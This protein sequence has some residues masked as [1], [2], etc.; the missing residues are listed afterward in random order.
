MILCPA[1]LSAVADGD[2]T[3]AVANR[4]MPDYDIVVATQDWHP[5]NHGSFAANHPCK[6]SFDVVDL[7]GLDQVL[8]PKKFA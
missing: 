4:L 8:W 2:A 7:C 3:I 6:Q 5:I 1:G